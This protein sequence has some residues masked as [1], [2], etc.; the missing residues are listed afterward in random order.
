MFTCVWHKFNRTVMRW[1]VDLVRPKKY[2]YRS[3]KCTDCTDYKHRK[4]NS[5]DATAAMRLCACAA[6]AQRRQ[7]CDLSV[8]PPRLCALLTASARMRFRTRMRLRRFVAAGS[9][10]TSCAPS[11]CAHEA[12]ADRRDGASVGTIRFVVCLWRP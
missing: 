12:L 3:L 7:P 11:K 6:S 10:A 5:A 4:P 2:R 1:R 9:S 8:A